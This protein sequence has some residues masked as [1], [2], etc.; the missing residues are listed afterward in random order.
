M[1]EV[2]SIG[3]IYEPITNDNGRVCEEIT[4]H[5]YKSGTCLRRIGLEMCA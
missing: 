5:D 1:V 4:E 2:T 3:R